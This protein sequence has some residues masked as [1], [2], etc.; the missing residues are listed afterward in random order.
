MDN[1]EQG[2]RKDEEERVLNKEYGISLPWSVA[3]RPLNRLD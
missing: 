1:I 3:H 2:A